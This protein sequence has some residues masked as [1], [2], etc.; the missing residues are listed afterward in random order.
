MIVEILSAHL[1]EVATRVGVVLKV[2][3]YTH[4]PAD[5]RTEPNLVDLSQAFSDLGV[6][7]PE[8]T[9]FLQQVRSTPLDQKVPH[10]P[11]QQSSTHVYENDQSDAGI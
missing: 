8:L 9:D 11:I 7:L 3:Y 4:T 5:N 6:S 10:Y 2:Y 1:L